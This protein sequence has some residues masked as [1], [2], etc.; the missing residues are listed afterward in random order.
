MNRRFNLVLLMI[1]FAAAAL[2]GGG[3]HLVHGVQVRRNASALL[4]Q[5]G[6][7]EAGNDL[8]KAEQSLKQ[9][10]SF[11]R[12]DGPAWKRYSQLLDQRDPQGRRRE[13][14][15][16]VYE[17]AL[18]YNTADAKLER[19]C[20]DLALELGRYSDAEP[21]PDPARQVHQEFARPARGRRNGRDRGPS[22]PMRA[23][24][25]PVRGSRAMVPEGAR[26]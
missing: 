17:Q 7:A 22:G 6:R 4:E 2:L 13:Q 11:R 14:V 10:L 18:R 1:L 20:A 26:A 12:E 5:A 8:E 21:P 16:L 3:I 23:G 19:R 24:I 25:E 15:F 9:Y